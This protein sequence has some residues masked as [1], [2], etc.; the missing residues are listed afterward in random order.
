M[1]ASAFLTCARLAG[2]TTAGAA[3]TGICAIVLTWIDLV[4]PS[5]ASACVNPC[6]ASLNVRPA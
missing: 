6:K 4:L 2:F 3:T 1:N 5:T